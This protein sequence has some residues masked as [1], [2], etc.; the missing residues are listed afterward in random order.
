M[1]AMSDDEPD[2][3][4]GRG[5]RPLWIVRDRGAE[6]VREVLRRAGRREFGD[7]TMI[8]PEKPQ[9]GS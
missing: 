8:M 2:F 5:G 6:G 4:Y 1:L 3:G 7:R 9:R